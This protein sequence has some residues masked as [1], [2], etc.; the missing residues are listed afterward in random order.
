MSQTQRQ[1]GFERE[2]SPVSLH[3]F[4]PSVPAPHLYVTSP[5]SGSQRITKEVFLPF[6]FYPCV[7]LTH[8]MHAASC[9]IFVMETCNLKLWLVLPK[10][11]ITKIRAT[12]IIGQPLSDAG[13]GPLKSEAIF[14]AFLP[15]IF[16]WGRFEITCQICQML[17]FTNERDKTR[18][19]AHLPAALAQECTTSQ[20]ISLESA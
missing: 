12:E 19:P 20:A 15:F 9:C 6:F 16:F 17:C 11:P 2:V 7:V 13:S 5:L 10:R 3:L 8:A 4:I 18:F 1:E 14:F